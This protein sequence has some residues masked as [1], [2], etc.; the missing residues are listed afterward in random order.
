[1]NQFMDEWMNEIGPAG[2]CEHNQNKL[3]SHSD[4]QIN[5][6][7]H[8]PIHPSIHPSLQSFIIARFSNSR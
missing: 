6:T 8:P 5:A 2:V 7:I 4:S 3:V 1:M